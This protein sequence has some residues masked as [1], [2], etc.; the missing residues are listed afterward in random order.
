MNTRT[1]LTATLMLALAAATLSP[2]PVQASHVIETTVSGRVTD[3]RGGDTIFVE[4][5]GYRV[6]PYSPAAKLIGQIRPGQVVDLV[7]NGD[8]AKE[9]TRVLVINVRGQPR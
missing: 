3:V 2:P 8:A 6:Q 5:R 7:L 1:R 4:G 9:S